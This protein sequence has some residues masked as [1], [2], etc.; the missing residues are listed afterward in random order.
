MRPD[1]CARVASQ[2][3]VESDLSWAWPMEGCKLWDRGLRRDI[4]RTKIKVKLKQY[5]IRLAL[6]R[7]F[8]DTVAVRKEGWVLKLADTA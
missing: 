7:H 5:I 8:V 1:Y 3:R 4:Y 6:T 2:P